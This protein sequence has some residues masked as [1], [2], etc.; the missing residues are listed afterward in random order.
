[1]AGN[2]STPGLEPSAINPQQR[3]SLVTAPVNNNAVIVL[4]VHRS[5]TS[6]LAG[7]LAGLGFHPGA[8]LLPAVAGVNNNGFFEDQRV[9]DLNDEV[10]FRLG[11]NWC[12]P[13]PLFKD[14]TQRSD[15]ADLRSR[16]RELLLEQQSF[17]TWLLKDP[18]MCQLLPLWL[19][20]MSAID[21]TPWV[22]LSYRDASEVCRSLLHRNAL[23]VPLAERLWLDHMLAAER[24]TRDLPRRLVSY[25]ELL[26]QPQQTLQGVIDWL[27]V[28]PSAAEVEAAVSSI[29]GS[30][31]HH[32]AA[33]LPKVEHDLTRELN[34]LFSQQAIHAAIDPSNVKESKQLTSV[35][36]RIHD[37]RKRD[38]A[39]TGF[40]LEPQAQ[41]IMEAE[42]NL[43]EAVAQIDASQ[44][45]TQAYGE[46]AAKS[47][48][49]AQIHHS[50]LLKAVAQ[51]QENATGIAQLNSELD[52]LRGEYQSFRDRATRV[53]G[54]QVLPPAQSNK[55][56]QVSNNYLGF[57]DLQVENNSHTRVIRYLREEFLADKINVLEIGCSEGY[58]GAA[59]K[60]DGHRVWGIETNAV[61]A[62]QADAVL[63]VVYRDSVEAFL[64]A[65]EFLGERFDAVIFGDVLEHL[66]D[67][68]RVLKEVSRRLTPRGVIVA[69]VPNVAHE[70]VRM[71]LLEGRWDYSATGIMDETHLHFFS[72]DTLV[73][74][75]SASALEVGR[76]STIHLDGDAVQIPVSPQTEALAKSVITD[77][78]RDVFQFVAMVRPTDSP[79][80]AKSKNANFKL[81]QQ[82]NILCL[83]PAPESSI[84]TIR[85][86]D[87][88]QRYTQLF[89]GELRIAPFGAPSESDIAWANTVVLQR[90]VT[91]AQLEMV[92]QLQ[93]RGKRV[94]FDIDDYLLDT[95]EYLSVHE[96]CKTMRPKLLAML[97]SVDAVSASTKPLQ[98]CLQ[99][100]LQNDRS[101]VFLTPNGAWS[102]HPPIEHFPANDADASTSSAQSD[103]ELKVRLL[104]A[105]SDSVRVDFLIDTLNQLVANENVELV[106]IGPPGD[107]LLQAGLP[108]ETTG[109]MP[110]EH[111]KGFAASRDNC[112]ALIPLDDNAFNRCKSAVK[113]FDYAL[114]GVPCVCSR[115][116]PYN[117]AV[118]HGVTGL[119]C[120]DDTDEWVA[121][122][123]ELIRT[124]EKRRAIA[125]AARSRVFATNNLNLT[126]AAW[127]RLF[128]A[129]P[130]PVSGPL[131]SPAPLTPPPPTPA[132]S[133]S[134]SPIAG[135]SD[136][137]SETESG[138]ATE[139]DAELLPIERRTKTQL[140]VGSMRHAL[141]P[142]SWTAAWR[143]YKKEGLSGL[144]NK[145][146]LVF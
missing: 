97:A 75:F 138:T 89:G 83:P 65:E 18:R 52:R 48:A 122:V 125:G 96:H 78:E 108:I 146:K 113:Y 129:T 136:D 58:F 61:A 134:P 70:R 93:A 32:K 45:A 56:E 9:V 21:I 8:A 15:L 105:S 143:I 72:R 27:G 95:P 10:L 67:P 38:A 57:I 115:V 26:A 20:E 100:C 133:P 80:S 35:L 42:A 139:V 40:L 71:M 118:E 39:A 33:E 41:K 103:P 36:D 114:A 85:L 116:E 74:L 144:K 92:E 117:D 76:L 44:K 51:L 3:D 2:K 66:L 59:L 29:S 30:E 64:L 84:Y 54:D 17:G 123:T 101:K 124:P 16:A 99:N 31:Q 55:R 43:Q 7:A 110:H 121:A 46:N 127:H 50:E 91:D 25:H 145:W 60:A 12:W 5:G 132:P 23:S 126:A 140:L 73:D 63:D 109:L 98:N 11:R 24:C 68:A 130:Y 119:L 13:T 34:Q 87:P 47:A 22:L 62:D 19:A 102:S 137:E 86:G 88:L 135:D 142:A 37:Q 81:S 106:G 49:D 79:E 112:I 94:V 1:M 6:A 69:S 111:F 14:W 104:V 131:C 141:R 4:G 128:E 90:E 120:S 28:S 53:L 82:H 107:Y 77:R